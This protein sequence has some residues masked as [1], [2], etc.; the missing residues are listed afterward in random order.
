MAKV[1]EKEGLQFIT[2]ENKD[3]EVTFSNLGAS[4]YSIVINGKYM[5]LTPKE[6]EDFA[7]PKL[8][9]GKTI[10]R[11]A[12]RIKGNKLSLSNKNYE[13]KNNEGENVLHGG[14]EG[15]STKIWEF[16]CGENEITFSY[17]SKE[18]ESG[19]PGNL[20]IRVKYTLDLEVKI[21]DV[22]YSAQSDAKTVCSLTNH[23]FFSLGEDSIDNLQLLIAG[24]NY[25]FP[26]PIDLVGV[27]KDE[28]PDYLDFSAPK[29]I[30]ENIDHSSL[31]NAKTKGYD[32]YFY[33][34]EINENTQI[35]L[36]GEK[37]QLTIKTDF[38]GVQ[39]YTDNYEDGVKYFGTN[40]DIHRGIAIEPSDNHLEIHTLEP[41]TAYKKH[42]RYQ[43]FE[44]SN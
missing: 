25:I 12:N 4:I 15:L 14:I 19:Y 37:Y 24:K 1:Y 35:I 23:A 5:T 36:S 8:F 41:N 38:E 39:I 43:F 7:N 31:Q 40:E 13:L 2:F 29:A 33:F 21:I 10:G 6:E 18:G 16:E 26:D 22:D 3:M 11:T 32:H 27:R 44:K 30:K 28:V 20:F 9:H 17:M 42:I 34:D